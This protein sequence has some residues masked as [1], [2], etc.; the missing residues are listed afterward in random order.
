MRGGEKVLAQI[1]TMLPGSDLYTLIHV[2]GSC[3]PVI[4]SLPIRT[5]WLSDLPGVGR[6]YR[7]LLGLMPWTIELFDLREYDLIVSCS[8]CVSKGIRRRGRALHACYCFTPMRYAWDQ[9]DAYAAAMG[10]AGRALRLAGPWLRSWDRRSADRVDLFLANSRN[11][12][13]RIGRI[14]GRRARVLH[15]PIDTEFF[16]PAPVERED[17]YLMVGALAPYKR[18]DQAIEAFAGSGRELRI[19][20]TGQEYARLR[21]RA[22]SNVRM[23]G[24]RSDEEVRDHFRRARALLFPGEEDFGMVP[25]EAMACGCPVIAYGAGGAL[26]TVV[27]WGGADLSAPTGL[28][29]TPQ[30]VEALR[31]A[32]DRMEHLAGRFDTGVLATWAGQFGPA[33]FAEG[34]RQALQSHPRGAE[35]SLPW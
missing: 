4:E 22:P 18:T 34:F 35:L 2:P 26:E 13:E 7:C 21:R 10:P 1:A 8:H 15:S 5:S 29:Y 11:V 30:T 27:P 6:Y 32:V 25:L 33:A 14:Y 24:W 20:G 28:L 23:L 3:D 31:A 16:T 19:I 17:F 12:A 9:A